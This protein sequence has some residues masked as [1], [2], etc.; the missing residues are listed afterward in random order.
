MAVGDQFP[1][2]FSEAEPVTTHLLNGPNPSFSGLERLSED[3]MLDNTRLIVREPDINLGSALTSV[4]RIT[5]R[6]PFENLV[7]EPA[8]NE[9][10]I[11]SPFGV[12]LVR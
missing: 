1:R 11:Q 3:Q 4:E 10:R 7:S 12:L 8:S 9:I 2:P 5:V 6:S